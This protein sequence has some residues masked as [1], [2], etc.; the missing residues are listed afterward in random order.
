M[1]MCETE[2]LKNFFKEENYL[3]TVENRYCLR[4]DYTDINNIREFLS[5]NAKN[6][7]KVFLRAF[8][9]IKFGYYNLENSG[10]FS[11]P[12]GEEFE[13]KYILELRLFNENEEILLQK[14][15]DMSSYKARIII[16]DV[17]KDVKDIQKI[18]TVDDA[19]TLF[20]KR[21][22]DNRI[23]GDFVKLKESGRKISLTIPSEHRAE[24]YALITRSY[25]TFDEKTGQAGISYYR[26]LDI[27]PEVK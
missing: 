10:E 11:F 8:N 20:G 15:D 22:I 2:E 5:Q 12:Y 26:Y 18:I 6:S 27:K 4:K 1:I 3:D 23:N 16:D 7:Y 14:N 21:T 24:Y 25:I 19:S 13:E 17:D 9:E